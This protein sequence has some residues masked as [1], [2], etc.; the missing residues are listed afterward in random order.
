LQ[1]GA[2]TEE[3]DDITMLMIDVR[4]GE[5][6]FENQ[7]ESLTRTRTM[8]ST[9]GKENNGQP[10]PHIEIAQDEATTFLIFVGKVSWVQ[11]KPVA[12]SIRNAVRKKHDIVV[13]LSTCDYLD[14]AMLGTL[15][16]TAHEC[17][18]NS[19]KL[20]IQGSSKPIYDAF[21]ELGMYDVL[22]FVIS[23]K[24]QVPAD[25]SRLSDEDIDMMA[26]QRWLLRAHEAL[27]SLN[28]ANEEEFRHVIE[29]LREGIEEAEVARRTKSSGTP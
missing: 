22:G 12:Q 17:S 6:Q 20:T 10:A 19:L 2:T 8:G 27:A 13:D 14:S 21:V 29:E 1:N 28:T 11:G 23:G 24:V 16:E 26:Q 25:R 9:T 7:F 18:L 15:H 4:E 5:N 3:Q